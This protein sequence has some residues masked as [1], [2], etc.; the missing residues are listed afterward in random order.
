MDQKTVFSKN[1]KQAWQVQVDRA[2]KFINE[3]SDDQ[4]MKEIAPGKNR[5]VYLMGH[6]IAIHDAIP[7]ILGFGKR[8]YPGYK[9][10]FIDA[11][12]KS[13]ADIPSTGELRQ[14]W[15]EVHER[16]KTEFDKI[17]ADS[18]FTRHES[19]T[20]EDFDKDP[21]RNKLSVFLGRTNH[22]AYHFGQLRLLK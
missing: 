6:L 9:Q 18:W 2:T 11:P 5:G 15:T 21:A 7:E 12:D 1:A 4:L 20:D 14:A 3:L 16:L 17:P 19:M 13:V 10:I 22:L 8:K